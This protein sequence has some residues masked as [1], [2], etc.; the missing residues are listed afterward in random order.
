MRKLSQCKRVIFAE[1][2]GSNVISSSKLQ[3]F[4]CLLDRN[5]LTHLHWN[6]YATVLVMLLTHAIW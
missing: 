2:C 3:R 4:R 6:M 1:F 5:I